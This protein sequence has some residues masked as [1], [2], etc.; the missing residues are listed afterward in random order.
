M[1]MKRL[2][3]LGAALA[4]CL[5]I[6][7]QGSAAAP[8]AVTCPQNTQTFSGS[9]STLVVPAGGYCAISNATITLDLI[10]GE[11]A[12]VDLLQVSIGRDVLLGNGAGGSFVDTTIGGDVIGGDDS[13]AGIFDSSIGGDLSLHG[14]DGGADLA[15]AHI[16]HD[17]L[18][19]DGAGTHMERTTIGHDLAA[20]QPRTVQTG[21]IGPDTPGGPVDVG[22]D[23]VI[24]GSPA[25]NPFVFDGICDLSVGHDMRVT[26]RT[27]TLGFG[28]ASAGCES[29]GQPGNTIGHDLVVTGNTAANGFFGPSSLRIGDDRVVHD[30]IFSGNTAVTGGHLEVTNNV[31]GHDALCSS[32]TPAVTATEPN[33]AGRLNTCG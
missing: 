32:N 9:A 15:N 13:G 29:S 23:V 14:G 24:D 11:G 31:V 25:D 8:A 33:T 4:A 2:M 28:I 26:N 10:L 22:H 20:S 21:Q 7:L 1:H 6:P 19:S 16:G 30:L 18:L 5:T 17:Y 27:V 3:A 12:G